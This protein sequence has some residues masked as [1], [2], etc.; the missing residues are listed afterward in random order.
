[1]C[2]STEHYMLARA[3]PTLFAWC[4]SFYKCN[5]RQKTPYALTSLNN[6]LI[7]ISCSVKQK[8]FKIG[9]VT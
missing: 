1:M 3:M 2:V 5:F 7:F 6:F 9:T 4:G 8:T